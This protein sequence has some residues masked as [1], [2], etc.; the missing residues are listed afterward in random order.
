M[1][2]VL[3]FDNQ[4]CQH[5]ATVIA[6]MCINNPGAHYFFLISDYISNE[7]QIKIKQQIHKA[8]SQVQFI[9]INK[10]LITFFPIGKGTAN[11]YISLAAY[12]RLFLCELLPKETERVLYVDCDIVVNGS[13]KDLWN[14]KFSPKAC[15]AAL[16]EQEKLKNDRTKILQYPIK[17]SYFNSGVML[18]NLT[19]MR[20]VYSASEAIRYIEEK[21][22]II[23]YHDQDVLNFFF[24]DKK[25]FFPL[26]YN[27][28]DIYLLRR[29]QLPQ[30][31]TH[32]I[33]SLRNPTII[34]FSGPIKPW[35]KECNHP[36]KE[37]YYYYLSKTEWNG[38][39]PQFK[40]QGIKERLKYLVITYIKRVL[41]FFNIK[42]YEF[43]EDLPSIKELIN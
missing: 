19:E 24:H 11:T 26:K 23:K 18:I 17:Y 40:Y 5:A 35:F 38:Y 31:Y 32:E 9:F 8:N 33:A 2:I 16:E 42:N 10:N 20:Q 22:N 43:R 34:H 7:N 3:T 15:I 25:D 41:S 27:V 4:Y 30:R 36:Y 12:Y 37:L 14:W 29:A 39:T 1:N 13:L 21:T 28:M 6:S